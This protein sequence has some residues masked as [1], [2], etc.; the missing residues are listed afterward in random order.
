MGRMMRLT[1]VVLLNI[2]VSLTL[3]AKTVYVGIG[4]TFTLDSSDFEASPQFSEKSKVEVSY[5]D[6]VNGKAKSAK[7][8]VAQASGS[9]ITILWNK[10]IMLYDKKAI[11]GQ[12]Y[13]TALGGVQSQSNNLNVTSLSVDGNVC[14][15][16]VRL[17]NPFIQNVTS[18]DGAGSY[19]VAGR[20]LGPQTIKVYVEYTTSKDGKTVPGYANCKVSNYTFSE[21]GSTPD[22]L[23]FTYPEL[24]SG[25]TATGYFL[26]MNKIG[27]AAVKPDMTSSELTEA[28][29]A[30]V[31][32]ASVR[33]F[34]EISK[35]LKS[36][37]PQNSDTQIIWDDSGK[38]V[39]TLVWT[40]DYWKDAK[41]GDMISPSPASDSSLGYFMY[42]TVYG[43]VVD[44]MQDRGFPLNTEMNNR[45][46]LAERLGLQ[47]DD[48][49]TDRKKRFLVLWCSP[50]A[51]FR[52]APDPEV[53]DFEAQ[54]SLSYGQVTITNSWITKHYQWK[55]DNSYNYDT[56]PSNAYP[57]T[58]FGYTYDWGGVES[59]NGFSEFV[60]L[61]DYKIE[62]ID[63]VL[64]ADFFNS[65]NQ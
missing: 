57:F 20:M 9:S 61:P 28:F 14:R 34:G 27:I 36:I 49:T 7:L 2:V 58:G 44:F 31:T 53:D 15:Q 6:P 38:R 40:G 8:K 51:I 1:V 5:V 30:A 13:S 48:G 45:L 64:T 52:P 10:S 23:S 4:S 60:V 32:D 46:C 22:T 63:N 56:N 19:T 25:V 62:V 43:E 24:K 41:A 16:T 35:S 26:F 3:S 11:K 21:D 37:T 39:K 54:L 33:E 42:V 59:V 47:V 50:E 17:C 12:L 18:S 29:K 55:L 65:L